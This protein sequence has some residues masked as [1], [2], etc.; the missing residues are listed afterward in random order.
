MS[1]EV[2]VTLRVIKDNTNE[3]KTFADDLKS[4]G[5]AAKDNKGAFDQMSSAVTGMIAAYAGMRG[6]QAVG[7]I[8][9]L[10]E[11]A[12]KA[13]NA[14]R[15]L[16]SSIG[17]Y[18]TLMAGLRSVTLGVADDMTLQQGA[19]RLLSMG[20]AT[21]AEEM[22][23]LAELAV[24]LGGAMGKD[25]TNSMN[26]FALMLANNSVRRLDNF[27]ISVDAVRQKM[28]ELK[29]TGM[30]TGEAFKLATIDVGQQALARLGDAAEAAATPLDR[31]HTN[32]QNIIQD[33]AQNVA[34]GANSLLGILQYSAGQLPQQVQAREAAGKQADSILPMLVSGM[35]IGGDI[36]PINQYLHRM[37]EDVA[38][39][40]ALANDSKALMEQVFRELGTSGDDLAK[41][42]NLS[43]SEVF[44]S[45]NNNQV[46]EQLTNAALQ[47]KNTLD[48]TAASTTAVAEATHEI[49]DAVRS[50]LSGGVGLPGWMG[51]ATAGGSGYSSQGATLQAMQEQQAR[52]AAEAQANAAWQGYSEAWEARM[53][54]QRANNFAMG[55]F[56]MDQSQLQA[57][58]A[59]AAKIV[60]DGMIAQGQANQELGDFNMKAG[61]VGKYAT[62]QTADELASAFDRIRAANEAGLISDE[63]MNKA[64]ELRDAAQ[65]A[66]D[67]F[68]KMSLTDVF[69]QSG[70]GL[71]GEMSDIV[72]SQMKKNGASDEAIAAAQKQFGLASGRET[73]SSVMFN[74]QIAPMLASMN[75]EQA[76]Q[77]MNNLQ[78]FMQQA[79]LNNLT[80]EQISQG[81]Q[82][83]V[84]AGGSGGQF[85]VTPF[86]G[87]GATVGAG[88]QNPNA[89]LWQK[90]LD[91]AQKSV[92]ALT[93]K[94]AAGISLTDAE[95]KKLD[96]LRDNIN[97]YESALNA[98]GTTAPATPG[99]MS[100]VSAVQAYFRSQG[101][102]VT[103]QQIM[104]AAGISDPRYLRPGT[105]N[106]PGAGAGM[107]PMQALMALLQNAM[108]K[109]VGMT[110]S[111]NPMEDGGL[112]KLVGKGAGGDNS[113]D[114]LG[115]A[116][117]D[118]SK[119]ADPLRT[120]TAAI[121]TNVG[122]ATT[123]M[124][125]LAASIAAIPSSRDVT[126]NVKVND[127][128]GGLS[129]SSG[130]SQPTVG[131]NTIQGGGNRPSRNR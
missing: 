123:N 32:L 35:G 78:V 4:T 48:Y 97:H 101:M 83:V 58:G 116:L 94:Q 56:G 121:A 122:T 106:L 29:A 1:N 17:D 88:A 8:L 87:G 92:D 126:I 52:R 20:L 41:Q 117:T 14:F 47:Y 21:S 103:Q 120:S 68:E 38:D 76:A 13:E 36:N 51:G 125:A 79:K 45:L 46:F 49:G 23:Q 118:A 114:K 90:Q 80:N 33:L 15:A 30:E 72:I 84:G 115:K 108:P 93:A 98:P 82:M 43:F 66:A 26:D 130:G 55:L 59:R 81:M 6:I 62:Q 91:S 70:G 7:E 3:L 12:N 24:K 44:D 22:N 64:K 10:G 71:A 124:D 11:G 19:S 96:K 57:A 50:G 128:D 61:A 89:E 127:P 67:A 109:E 65:N 73:E 105:Y 40:P 129:L 112:G 77:A 60:H 119:A 110:G 75:P 131:H 74:E 102:D 54:A 104:T 111:L 100:T 113:Y 42:G 86:G 16:S 34:T 85:T 37:M 99:G 27:G 25:A 69:G 18:N 2:T 95:Q 107:D 9:S 31:V 39:N 28:N 5:Q 63:D 53:Q